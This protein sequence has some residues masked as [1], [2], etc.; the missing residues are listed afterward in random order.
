[1][2]GPASGCAGDNGDGNDGDAGP[3]DSGAIDATHDD[4]GSQDAGP[5]DTGPVDVG[6]VNNPPLATDDEVDASGSGSMLITVLYND[7]D[8]DGDKLTI[9]SADKP[10]QGTLEIVYGQ[11]VLKYTPT[12]PGFVGTDVFD[13]TVSDGKGGKDTATIRV[14]Y[15]TVPKIKILKPSNGATAA[16]GSV[17][18]EWTASGCKLSSPNANK[19]G[20]HVH[21]YI[22]NKYVKGLYNT[23]PVP[24]TKLDKGK[25]ALALRVHVNAGGD[26]PWKPEVWDAINV[27]VP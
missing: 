27:T 14:L 17:T 18:L 1:M 12:N 2:A 23:A 19:S 15:K 26:A 13:Y 22:D 6:P 8:Y 10:K 16:G 3:T 20:C 9:V 11:T 4:A 5:A 7:G 21:L 25:H 24:I